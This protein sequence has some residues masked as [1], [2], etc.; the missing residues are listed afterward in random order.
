MPRD[1][2][3]DLRTKLTM[4]RERGGF[5]LLI[6]DSSVGKTRALFQMVW[7]DELQNYLN[8]PAELRAAAITRLVVERQLDRPD[9]ARALLLDELRRMPNVR[10]DAAIPQRMR[11][12]MDEF[13]TAGL[14]GRPSSAR[15]DARSWRRPGTDVGVAVAA[16]RP[17]AGLRGRADR[18]RPAWR[19]RAWVCGTSTGPLAWPGPLGRPTY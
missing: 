16:L 13:H 17:D 18:G 9:E 7:L 15:P 2:D 5:V 8:H 11:L 1:L 19:T 12:V 3:V 14:P 6:G 4:A 10:A